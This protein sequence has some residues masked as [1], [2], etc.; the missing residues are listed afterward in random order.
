M[1]TAPMPNMERDN[2]DINCKICLQQ[3]LDQT[4]GTTNKS[5]W[6]S[7]LKLDEQ[8]FCSCKDFASICMKS[9]HFT[10]T[11]YRDWLIQLSLFC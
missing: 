9:V 4:E 8:D 2:P 3:K 1:P 11:K 5:S 6:F 10:N 7:F